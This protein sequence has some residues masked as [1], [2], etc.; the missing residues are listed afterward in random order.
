M[1]VRRPKLWAC[2]VLRDALRVVFAAPMMYYKT[3][4]GDWNQDGVRNHDVY[5][6]GNVMNVLKPTT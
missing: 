2:S 6:A 4:A 3:I 5:D 1:E